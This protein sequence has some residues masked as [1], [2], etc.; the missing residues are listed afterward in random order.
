VTLQLRHNLEKYPLPSTPHNISSSS[1]L[2]WTLTSYVDEIPAYFDVTDQV[3]SRYSVFF[4]Q[5]R[6]NRS[7]M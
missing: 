7:N 4:T 5:R 3:V 2:L 1:I 6:K